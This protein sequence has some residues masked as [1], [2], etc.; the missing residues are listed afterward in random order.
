MG[1]LRERVGARTTRD[2]LL[3]FVASVNKA[4]RN[5]RISTAPPVDAGPGAS[6]HSRGNFPEADGAVFEEQAAKLTTEI[7][8]LKAERDS[9]KIKLDGVLH[10]TAKAEKLQKERNATAA[11]TLHEEIARLKAHSKKLVAEAK[12]TD[13]RLEAAAANLKKQEAHLGR[14]EGELAKARE[15][16][17]IYKSGG[18]QKQKTSKTGLRA[19]SHPEKKSSTWKHSILA[20]VAGTAIAGSAFG[21]VGGKNQNEPQ[22]APE[23]ARSQVSNAGLVTTKVQEKAQDETN[24][25]PPQAVEQAKARDANRISGQ[26]AKALAELKALQIQTD[27]LRKQAAEEQATVE[28]ALLQ[29]AEIESAIVAKQKEL[30]ALND[31]KLQSEKDRAATAAQ[32]SA[33]QAKA[34]PDVTA[35]KAAKR[36]APKQATSSKNSAQSKTDTKPKASSPKKNKGGLVDPFAM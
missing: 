6:D 27:S 4:P 29:K 13:K 25:E 14:V 11:E 23:G 31:A 26:N 22:Q 9:L 16:L 12:P 28:N 20:F 33:E 21:L 35:K 24:G 7:A 36:A 5:K 17:K 1:Q 15:Q 2:S 8:G 19:A 30:E 10:D 3:D 32:R 18:R 34:G